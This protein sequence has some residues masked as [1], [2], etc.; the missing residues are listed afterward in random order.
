[1]GLI[2]GRRPPR[3]RRGYRSRGRAGFR[4]PFPYYS[5]R[6]RGGSRMTVTGCCLPIPLALSAVS[7]AAARAF[8]RR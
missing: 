8:L 5:R 1:V 3:G 2:F 7:L 4:G 6:T